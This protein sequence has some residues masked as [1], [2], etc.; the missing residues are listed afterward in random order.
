[1]FLGAL[2]GLSIR[3]NSHRKGQELG[4]L[5]GRVL[6]LLPTLRICQ[7]VLLGHYPMICDSQKSGWLLL[8]HHSTLEML[9]LK[10]PLLNTAPES[11]GDTSEQEERT[12]GLMS[13]NL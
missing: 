12:V 4:G 10:K 7:N 13:A 1:L 9:C 6:C 11:Y 3:G 8:G 2:Q 5:L